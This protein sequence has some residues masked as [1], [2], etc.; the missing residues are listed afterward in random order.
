VLV[1]NQPVVKD[2]VSHV[3]P[4]NMINALPAH[5]QALQPDT[6]DSVCGSAVLFYAVGQI[7]FAYTLHISSLEAQGIGLQPCYP[8]H[9]QYVSDSPSFY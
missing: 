1:I 6:V 7:E 9:F 5:Q 3:K 4:S 8:G 2:V